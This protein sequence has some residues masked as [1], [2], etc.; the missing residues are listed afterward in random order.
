MGTH[1][2]QL[3]TIPHPVLRLLIGYSLAAYHQHDRMPLQALRRKSK[4]GLACQASM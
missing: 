3:E 4:L 2:K 1:F